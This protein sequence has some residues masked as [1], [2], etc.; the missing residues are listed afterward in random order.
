MQQYNNKNLIDLIDNYIYEN[1][2]YDGLDSNLNE[3]WKNKLNRELTPEEKIM[4][5][6]LIKEKD[7]NK[8]IFYFKKILM[9]SNCLI[10]EKTNYEGDC[11]FESL[12]LLN[13]ENNLNIISLR[14]KIANILLVVKDETNFFP[15]LN[16]SPLQIFNNMNEIEYVFNNDLN[17]NEVKSFNNIKI[18]YDFNCMINDLRTEGSWSRL[19]TEL[20]LMSISRIYNFK[21]LIYHNKTHYITEIN[22]YYDNNYEIIRLGLI[23][24]NHYFPVLELDKELHNN[25][26]VI[27][28][29]LDYKIEYTDNF[30]I[31]KKWKNNLTQLNNSQNET[32]ININEFYFF[33]N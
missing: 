6:K 12:I 9:K 31:F 10:K 25:P 32:N 17:N 3:K 27:K 20:I 16:L 26:D 1:N 13:I 11:M 19:P 14:D 29:I 22:Q 23:N 4:L 21:I 2:L 24:E 33:K 30:N 15:K 5:I 8:D 7:L 28:Q 18:K